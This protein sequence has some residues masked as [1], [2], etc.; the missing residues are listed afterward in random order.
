MKIP[1]RNYFSSYC[2]HQYYINKKT[3]DNIDNTIIR[4]S[5][6]FHSCFEVVIN[7][8]VTGIYVTLVLHS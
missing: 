4:G 3:G 2:K 8:N 7:S 5:N 6:V 1:S